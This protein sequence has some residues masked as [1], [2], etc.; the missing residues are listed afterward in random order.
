MYKDRTKVEERIG[1]VDCGRDGI[2]EVN[3]SLKSKSQREDGEA[4]SIARAQKRG[5]WMPCNISKRRWKEERTENGNVYTANMLMMLRQPNTI[6]RHTRLLSLLG[7]L[8]NVGQ[9][10]GEASP[11]SRL[12]PSSMT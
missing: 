4:T 3:D 2:V 12:K 11:L 10:G 1:Q 9:R 5:A 6:R 7:Q 8:S